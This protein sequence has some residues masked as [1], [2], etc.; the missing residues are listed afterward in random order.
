MWAGIIG[1]PGD[2]F[3]T[4]NNQTWVLEEVTTVQGIEGPC[5]IYALSDPYKQKTPSYILVT[6]HGTYK[7]YAKTKEK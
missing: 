6:K 5:Y 2:F 7:H 1:T 4:A 3:V